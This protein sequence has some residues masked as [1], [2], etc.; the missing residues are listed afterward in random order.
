MGYTDH[1][2][3]RGV[4]RLMKHY[5]LVAKDVGDLT[6]IFCAALEA[7]QRKPRLSLARF[8]SGWRRDLAGFRVDGERLNIADADAFLKDP[9]NFMRLFWVAQQQ[10]LDIH[11]GALRL[12]TQNLRR[13]DGALRDNEE[14]NKLFLEIL[15]SRNDPETA[16]RRMNEAGV[17]GRFVPEFAASSRRCQYDMYHVYTVDEHTL[18][19]IGILSRVERGLLKD[20]LPLATSLM[21][22]LQSRR[23]L[24]R[25]AAAARHRQGP[26]AATTPSSARRS[27]T[28][29]VRAS[30]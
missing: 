16:L 10:G 24:L 30:G 25:R 29:S 17:F 5:F 4:E 22:K 2:G 11:P 19:A 8:W 23:A 9:V 13:I 21:P 1:A 26:A 14:A 12:I 3:T 7:E 6:R 18:F 20:E 27:P 28:S 15:T